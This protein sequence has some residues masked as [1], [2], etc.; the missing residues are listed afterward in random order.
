MDT[1]HANVGACDAIECLVLDYRLFRAFDDPPPTACAY[2]MLIRI[3][4]DFCF[5]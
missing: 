5:E 4:L 2:T 1:Y 3:L